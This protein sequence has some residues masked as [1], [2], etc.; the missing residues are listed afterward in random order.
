M[1]LNAQGFGTSG[2]FLGVLTN[3]LSLTDPSAVDAFFAVARTDGTQLS[4]SSLTFNGSALPVTPGVFLNITGLPATTGI[5]SPAYVTFVNSQ[6]AYSVGGGLSSEVILANSLTPAENQSENQAG[7]GN[8]NVVI[9]SAPDAS[10]S[11]FNIVGLCLPADQR[12]D[13]DAAAHENCTTR[14]CRS[15]GR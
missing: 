14:W 5:G 6:I 10:V 4:T 12:V 15:A 8:L 7:T 3:S 11:L 2:N 1:S 9:Q 13:E